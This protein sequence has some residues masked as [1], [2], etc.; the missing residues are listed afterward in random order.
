[1][2][3]VEG[4]VKTYGRTRA[5]NGLSLRVPCGSIYGFVGPN[6]AGKTT[7]LRI[8]ATLLAPEG[9]EAWVDGRPLTATRSAGTLAAVRSKIGY[10]PDFFGVYDNLTVSEYL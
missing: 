4:L 3:R 8:L 6:G 5:L 1:M 2:L 10:M 7:T 9:G